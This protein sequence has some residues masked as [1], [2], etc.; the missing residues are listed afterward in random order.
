M[1]AMNWRIA[2]ASMLALIILVAVIRLGEGDSDEFN[3]VSGEDLVA[4]L[5]RKA[6]LNK[7]LADPSKLLDL[8]TPHLATKA[9]L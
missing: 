4:A 1:A 5:K 9:G 2:V 7:K 3:R 8:L 6:A